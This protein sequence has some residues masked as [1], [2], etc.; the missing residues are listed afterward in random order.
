MFAQYCNKYHVTE[1]S[2]LLCPTATFQ[3]CNILHLTQKMVTKWVKLSNH[4]MSGR[5][6]LASLQGLKHIHLPVG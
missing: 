4:Y 1:M 6:H 2:K 3:E 5:I